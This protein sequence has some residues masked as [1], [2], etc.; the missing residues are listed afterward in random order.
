MLAALTKHCKCGQMPF[1]NDE[2]FLNEWYASL[3][4]KRRCLAASKP[5][6]H[7]ADGQPG[8][9]VICRADGDELVFERIGDDWKF[10]NVN[11]AP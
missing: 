11:P 6:A 7:P 9:S 3:R 4:R 8:Y 5:I 10:V 2:L 1:D